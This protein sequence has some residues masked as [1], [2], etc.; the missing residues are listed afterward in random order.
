MKMI[1]DNTARKESLIEILA[2]RWNFNLT[3]LL[4]EKERYWFIKILCNDKSLEYQVKKTYKLLDIYYSCFPRLYTVESVVSVVFN[5]FHENK[6]NNPFHHLNEVLARIKIIIECRNI[7][8]TACKVRTLCN[9]TKQLL[10]LKA[11]TDLR[12]SVEWHSINYESYLADISSVVI[13]LLAIL[14]RPALNR[15]NFHC[16]TA[17]INY[18]ANSLIS[19]WYYHRKKPLLSQI[20]ICKITNNSIYTTRN[21]YK[22]LKNSI[23]SNCSKKDFEEFIQKN[24]TGVY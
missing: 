6:L 3:S 14:T 1:N 8:D 11:D 17:A 7:L 10:L 20:D 21:C 2:T 9:V 5:V 13:Y 22:Y 24:K 19:K 18:T 4:Q 16:M 15:S 23:L 12:F